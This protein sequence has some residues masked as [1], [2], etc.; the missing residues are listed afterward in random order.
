M[1]EGSIQHNPQ[2]MKYYE[3]ILVDPKDSPYAR[4]RFHYRSWDQLQDLQL[5]REDHPRVIGS[6]TPSESSMDA[7]GAITRN[8]LDSIREGDLSVLSERK[9]PWSAAISAICG[10]D[11]D[12]VEDEPCTYTADYSDEEDEPTLS[13]PKPQKYTPNHRV[14]RA[15]TSSFSNLSLQMMKPEK[16]KPKRR[17]L[18]DPTK[19]FPVQLPSSHSAQ[20]DRPLPNPAEHFPEQLPRSDL[21]QWDRPLPEPPNGARSTSRS[22]RSATDA[23]LNA[24]SI[25]PSLESYFNCSEHSSSDHEVSL[26]TVV[27]ME[28][29]SSPT[30]VNVGP[31]SPAS[32]YSAIGAHEQPSFAS[33]TSPS[34]FPAPPTNHPLRRKVSVLPPPEAYFSPSIAATFPANIPDSFRTLPEMEDPFGPLENEA[35]RE[36]SYIGPG[37]SPSIHEWL[38]RTPSP[39]Q[40]QPF[41]KDLPDRPSSGSPRF[42]GSTVASRAKARSK[43]PEFMRAREDNSTE[44]ARKQSRVRSL[45]FWRRRNDKSDDGSR[46]GGSGWV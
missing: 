40:M 31:N 43:T 5:I 1:P 8:S 37:S 41:D 20:S 3:W 22:S 39:S 27:R 14:Q 23:E 17:P 28:L 34:D 12:E 11:P 44:E 4:F 18:P 42:F 38:R 9:A 13:A 33:F 26:G 25:K 29:A 24:V 6:P 19:L 15:L 35:S 21:D 36:E 7:T 10:P 32:D 16:M 2:D 46:R 30:V 45:S